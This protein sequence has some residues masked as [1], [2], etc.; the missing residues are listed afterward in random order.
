GAACGLPGA[1]GRPGGGARGGPRRGSGE[2][3]GPDHLPR[4]NYLSGAGGWLLPGQPGPHQERVA[5]AQGGL[6]AGS[7]S[8]PGP[9]P[10]LIASPLMPIALVSP[11][12]WTLPGRVTRHIAELATALIGQAHHV[13]VLAPVD[14]DDPPPRTPPRR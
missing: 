9:R 5:G 3:F 10:R 2:R 12:S 1:V 11:Y 6:S 14:P 13:R 7:G 4:R 8:P